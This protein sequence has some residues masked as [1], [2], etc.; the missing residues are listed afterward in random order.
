MADESVQ[1][2]QGAA[3]DVA[4]TPKSGRQCL[5]WQRVIPAG[6]D[7]TTA[8]AAAPPPRSGAASV[9]LK[10]KLYVYG[11]YGGGTG[12]LDDFWSF[13][14]E[15]GIWEEVQVLSEQK[16]GCR[17]NNGVVLSDN[18][19]SIYIFGGYNGK[20]LVNVWERLQL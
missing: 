8:A 10:S 5:S 13:D 9:V 2:P 3:G 6:S 4:R 19:R 15:K 7:A 17:E 12:R 14:F 11:G 20:K 16:P 18:N 1:R